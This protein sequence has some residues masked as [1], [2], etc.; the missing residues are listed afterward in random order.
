MSSEDQVDKVDNGKCCCC[1]SLSCG[2]K[3][4]NVLITINFIKN[5]IAGSIAANQG[6]V[7][8]WYLVIM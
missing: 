3:T 6:F 1:F 5:I 2:V 7:A 4:L 8:G